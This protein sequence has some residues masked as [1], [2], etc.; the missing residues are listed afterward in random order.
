[1]IK[2]VKCNICNYKFFIEKDKVKEVLED[3]GVNSV[4][5]GR[6]TYDAIDCPNCGCQE[7]LW[8][9]LKER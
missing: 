9:R 4:L 5:T 6:K 1:M 2:K 8:P 3:K 7:I